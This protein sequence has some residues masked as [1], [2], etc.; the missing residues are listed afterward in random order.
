MIPAVESAGLDAISPIARGAEIIQAEIIRNLETADLVLCDISTFNPNVFFELGIRTAVDKPVC[1]V[2]DRLTDRIPFDT[3]SVNVHTYDPSLVSW[4]LEDELAKL[5]NHCQAAISSSRG[6]NPLWRYFSLS[7]RAS[8]TAEPLT[9]A[10]RVEQQLDLVLQ[11]LR[12]IQ[13]PTGAIV[14][15]AGA[16][17]DPALLDQ[18]VSAARSFL[19]ADGAESSRM[20][21]GG[22]GELAMDLSDYIVRTGTRSRIE[23]LGQAFGYKV[24][25]VGGYSGF[26]DMARKRL[27][28]A[29]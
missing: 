10:Q 8:F 6:R 19:A 28:N 15:S 13:R 12:S 1:M 2:K 9:P 14:V 3:A 4:L 5:A 24:R 21:L 7:T 17:A 26:E 25:F 16:E 11:E 27:Y 18:F 22:D 20:V 23:T 29:E